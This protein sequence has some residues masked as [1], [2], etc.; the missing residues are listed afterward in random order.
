MSQLESLTPNVFG[1]TGGM[2]SGKSTV[3][4]IYAERGAVILDADQI[5]RDLQEPGQTGLT[6][7]VEIL[8]E[9]ILES[10][11]SLDRKA[12]ARL[13]FGD[14]EKRQAVEA[15]LHPLIWSEID[16]GIEQTDID[17]PVILDVP[18]LLESNQRDLSGIIV[19]Y[20]PRHLAVTRLVKYRGFTEEDALARISQ[21]MSPEERVRQADFIIH[22]Y[23]SREDVRR[24]IDGGWSWLTEVHQLGKQALT[25]VVEPGA[26]L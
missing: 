14:A 24:Q 7:M 10:G 19:V 3:S 22:N 23:G 21:Q 5:V 11:G 2:G 16:R 25:E 26:Q 6:G 12:A 4:A 1:L 15:F 13:I 9:E 8:G 17:T 20:A 18:L